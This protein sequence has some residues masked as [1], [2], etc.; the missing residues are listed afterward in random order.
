MKLRSA[1]ARWCASV[2][3]ATVAALALVQSAAP[4]HVVAAA[5][6]ESVAALAMP[7]AKIARAEVL[8]AGAPPF[9][10]SRAFCRVLVTL[11]PTSDS[12]IN[13]EVWLP[14]DGWNGKFQ[15]VGNGDA[16][17][18]ISHAE[19]TDAIN[20][21]FATSSTD[22]GH[23]GNSMAF[24]LGHREKYIDF[25]YRSLHEMT[26]HAKAIIGAFTVHRRGGRTGKGA[27]RADGRASPRRRVIRPTTTR[28]SPALRRSSTCSSMPRASR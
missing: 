16:A 8:A 13:V 15:A 27:R 20:R 9:R 17:G 22:T 18:V 4:V 24:A 23:V 7:A 6:C 28:S 11:R 3:L 10:A 21:G 1:S 5:P 26:V 25:G 19:M 12:D 14:L 2:S